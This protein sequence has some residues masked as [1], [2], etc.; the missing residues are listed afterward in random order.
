MQLGTRTKQINSYGKRN[1][2]V[3]DVTL[4][5]DRSTANSKLIS[6]FDDLPPAPVWTSVASKMKKRDIIT[7]QKPLS[8]K[9]VGLG[10]RRRLSPVL[11]PLKRKQTTRVAQIIGA[12]PCKPDGPADHGLK[13]KSDPVLI[14]DSPPRAPLSPFRLNMPGSPAVS[15][16]L[17]AKSRF[18]SKKP[19]PSKLSKPFS[20]FVDVDIMVL[21]DE[22]RTVRKERRV[23]RT[24]GDA[25]SARQPPQFPSKDVQAVGSDGPEAD[26]ISQPR[27]PKRHAARKQAIIV[28]DD[29]ESEEENSPPKLPNRPHM[30][31]SRITDPSLK[32]SGTTHS[33]VEIVVPAAPYRIDRQ[34]L[35]SSSILPSPPP[36]VPKQRSPSPSQKFPTTLH[37]VE[38]A[39]P[40]ERPRQR[41]VTSSM[42]QPSSPP[43]ASRQHSLSQK[44]LPHFAPPPAPTRY[45]LVP[46]PIL[47]TR[48]LTPIRGGR[49]KRLFDPPSPPSPT[50]PTDF[51]L[52]IDFSD[53]SIESLSQ[54]QGSY[55]SEFEVPKYLKP[56]LEECHQ[57][58]CG[59]HNF[60]AFI[61]SFPFDPIISRGN[62]NV[63]VRFRKIGEASYSEVFGI[64]DVVLKVIPLRDESEAG[65]SLGPEE[66]DGPAPT[67][68]KDVR[69]EIIVTRAMGEVYNGFVKLLKTYVVRGRYPEVLLQLWDEYNETK[70][71]ESVRPD[72]F[73]VSQVYA[74][75]V[76]PNG[77]PDLEAYAFYNAS[78]TGWRQASSLFWQVA[79]ALAHA[80]QLVSFEHRDLHWGQILV[81][82]IPTQA[83]ALKS[84][85]INQ[86]A[87]PRGTRVPMDDITH[88]LVVTV[89]DLGLSRMDAGDGGDGEHVHWTPFDEEV[90]MGE[91]DYQF[92]V[93]RIMRELTRDTW[94][95]FH[96]ITNVLWLHYLLRKLLHA[97]GLKPPVTPRKTKTETSLPSS[98]A[99]TPFTEKDCYD[100]LV[101]LESWLNTSIAEIVPGAAKST[102]KGKG[103]RKTQAPV[104]SSANSGPARAA[105]LV[106]Y[107]VKK[108]WIK[109][110]LL[111]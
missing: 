57:D 82:T 83:N 2:R 90:F 44:N 58:T 74:I 18:A 73:K 66:E 100:C 88:G 41:V 107:G 80:E 48:Q 110:S 46:S 91:G 47:K 53:L 37:S 67:D 25:N 51:D 35:V 77:G 111:L 99:E 69:K 34:K 7:K 29:S 14:S 103:R 24:G 36:K 70:G 81:K 76:L 86:R 3:V 56:L 72:T 64:G 62:D 98:N 5:T 50:T 22:G 95:E 43:K 10:K 60:S 40:P 30:D 49:N 106:A 102:V 11:S 92:D 12:E 4:D 6:I 65:E 101:D 105:E 31:G 26:V 97:K 108:G 84:L 93:Y 85:T 28:S 54:T 55:R 27:R 61:E 20:P 23:S 19:T 45:P 32:T 1:R 9:V 15:K 96:P 71:S 42:I 38:I 78:R 52:S 75:I 104:K 63:D 94:E 13:K 16:K 33:V 39:V 68:A 87:K 89:I 8:P 79:K 59:P 109:P 21:D 17:L